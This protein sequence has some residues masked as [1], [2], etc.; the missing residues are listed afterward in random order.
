MNKS[1]TK[2]TYYHGEHNIHCGI[3]PYGRP[4]RYCPDWSKLKWRDRIE[5]ALRKLTPKDWVY[6]ILILFS[7]V[8]CC[9]YL[10]KILPSFSLGMFFGAAF[11]VYCCLAITH[12]SM[13]VFLKQDIAK[14]IAIANL[15]LAVSFGLIWIAIM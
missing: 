5:K 10:L 1:C 2:C 3:Y 14:V 13:F 11:F 8:F 4:D 9:F 6:T 7:P 12:F 15:L